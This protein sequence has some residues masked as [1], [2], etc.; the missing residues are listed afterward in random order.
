MANG[1]LLHLFAKLLPPA[2]KVCEGYVFTG[3]CLSIGGMYPSMPY[4]RGWYP[5]MHCRFHPS[6]P[7][8]GGSPGPHPGEKLRG[9]AR[10]SPGPH[11]EGSPGPH[12]RSGGVSQHALRQTPPHG[13]LL[14]RVV[15]TGMHSCLN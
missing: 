11:P 13:R 3:V 6:M 12:Q 4:S 15:P 9:L 14:P 10:G 2:N 1:L 5:S 7:C 8:K